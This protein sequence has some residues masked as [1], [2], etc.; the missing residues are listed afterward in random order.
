MQFQR[1]ALAKITEDPDQPRKALDET[2]LSSL[3]DSI[4]Q[5]GVLN[6][7]TV[8]PLLGVDGY[9]IVTGERRW[10]AAQKAG[11]FEMPCVVREETEKQ[12]E[13]T[14]RAEQ[15]IENLQREEL[16][17]LDKAR[18]MKMLKEN[19]GAT[20]KEIGTRL[21]VSERTVGYL[22]DLLDLPET[23]GEQI[24]SSPNR[25]ADGNL[26]EK[27]GRFLRQ[28]NE[29]PEIQERLVEKIRGEKLS[30]DDT[31]RVAKALR[32]NPDK[33]EE[34]LGSSLSELPS[35]VGATGAAAATFTTGKAF[36]SLL[37]RAEATVSE[38]N[39]T[40]VS[41]ADLESVEEALVKVQTVVNQRLAEVRA[42]LR[43]I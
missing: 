39:A 27:H 42:A 25:P 28:L 20:N 23:I 11:L 21:A 13:A 7:I 33:Y 41:V 8:V 22:L 31:G 6:P 9:R 40:T 5:H 16:S 36:V 18:A 4:R 38:V 30:A 10:R 35:I 24:I 26:T 43:Q 14:T 32:D 29:E 19:L 2:A 12:D 1:I 3:A 15:L 34:I 17:P 37:G